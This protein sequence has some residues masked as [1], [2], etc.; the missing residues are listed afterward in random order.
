MLAINLGKQV[1]VPVKSS[2]CRAIDIARP[3]VSIPILRPHLQVETLRE[4]IGESERRAR[5][6]GLRSGGSN[7]LAR[8]RAAAKKQNRRVA[9][10]IPEVSL[11]SN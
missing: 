1:C 9:V 2:A 3:C 8:N 5:L 6:S 4:Q 7:P 11:R 10:K